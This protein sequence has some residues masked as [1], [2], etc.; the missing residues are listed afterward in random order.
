MCLG[1]R[2]PKE[3]GLLI[4]WAHKGRA[5]QKK[6]VRKDRLRQQHGPMLSVL[7]SDGAEDEVEA[8]CDSGI[9]KAPGHQ[10]SVIGPESL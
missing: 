3:I 8:N 1:L 6:L 5:Q 9:H 7:P 2:E 10:I 4:E